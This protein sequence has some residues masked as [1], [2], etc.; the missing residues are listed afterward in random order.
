MLNR[1]DT[2]HR[3]YTDMFVT[4]RKM[5]DCYAGAR[6]IKFRKGEYLPIPNSQDTSEENQRKY[7]SYLLRAQYLNVISPTVSIMEGSIF[8]R[9]PVVKVPDEI[10]YILDD[11][12][13]AEISLLDY[14]KEVLTD[15]AIMGRYGLLVDLDTIETP[16]NRAEELELGVMPRFTSYPAEN[17][18]NWHE[19]KIDGIKRPDMITVQEE[20]EEIDEH[21]NFSYNVKVI[22]RKLY[23]DT[24]TGHYTQELWDKDKQLAFPNGDLTKI[25]TMKGNIPF[26]YIP[27]VFFGITTNSSSVDEPP[28]EP[29]AELSIGHFR[30]SADFEE[31]CFLTGQTT[32]ILAGLPQAWVDQNMK[33]GILLGAG[34]SL[35]LPVGASADLIQANPNNIAGQA[36]KD[37]E[38][39]ML[40]LGLRSTDGTKGRETAKAAGMRFAAH[41][42]IMSK[43]SSNVSCGLTLGLNYLYEYVTGNVAPKDAIVYKLSKQFSSVIA[44]PQLVLQLIASYQEG[45]ITFDELRDNLSE[46]GL[47]IDEE[48]DIE[49][50][51]AKAQSS[52]DVK[53]QMVNKPQVPVTETT[54]PQ[55][56]VKA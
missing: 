53:Q 31:T 48:S 38:E 2:C 24:E 43:L 23:I 49:E 34:S 19:S 11:A 30:N 36:M 42:A 16:N 40:K 54:P 46:L 56:K 20:R 44:D 27:F 29:L 3:D 45:I 8:K 35:P 25:P 22:Q 4:W 15:V 13:G 32:L 55:D 1:A 14:A 7:A 51:Q 37:K 41:E 52:I 47:I 18:L 6:K 12:A 10:K 9:E 28:L 50:L 39:N 21:N 26:K 33:A 5:R 17:I